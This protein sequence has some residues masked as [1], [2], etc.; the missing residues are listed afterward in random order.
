MEMIVM[1]E[2]RYSLGEIKPKFHMVYNA[3]RLSF[4]SNTEIDSCTDFNGSIYGFVWRPFKSITDL[5]KE[6]DDQFDFVGQVIACEDLDNYD[7]NRKAE[8]K[9]VTL[10]DDEGN[11]IKCTLWGN[12][13]QQF[14]DF[15]NSYDDHG[16]IVLARCVYKM[17]IEALNCI[18]LIATKLYMKMN[19]KRLFANQPS[20]QSKN[21]ATKIS[22][23]SKNSTTDTFVNK[24]PIRNIDALLDME[25]SVMWSQYKKIKVGGT[26]DAGH[27]VARLK[28]TDYIDL[29][30][31]M[32]K[33]PD[34]PN[35]W[36]CIKCNAWVALIKSQV[37]SKRGLK[38]VV[39]DEEGNVSKTTTNVV[40]KEVLHG[41]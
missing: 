1:D 30:S 32:P 7:K 38:V 26:S 39:C 9:P 11:E 23:A 6:E 35:D 29:E 4:L 33:K 22:T 28:S 16:R 40:Y 24:H 25:Q 27:A 20:E 41:L 13:A 36:L 12:Y 14:N 31:E 19:T 2:H 3:M 8:K 15:L 37:K 10:I 18:F 17:G 21:T 34:K 5:E